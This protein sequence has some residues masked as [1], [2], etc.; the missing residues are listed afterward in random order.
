MF[1]HFGASVERNIHHRKRERK[2]KKIRGNE[3]KD[4][5]LRNEN[6]RNEARARSANL[7][8]NVRNAC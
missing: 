1:A 2:R 5:K 4:M 3:Q 8:I 6:I 7:S